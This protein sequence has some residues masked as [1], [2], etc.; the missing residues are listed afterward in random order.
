MPT[1]A[2]EGYP[3]SLTDIDGASTREPAESRVRRARDRR[4]VRAHRSCCGCGRDRIGA[5]RNREQT[6]PVA[7]PLVHGDTI[8]PDQRRARKVP[9]QGAVGKLTCIGGRSAD[10]HERP[11]ARHR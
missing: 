5:A 8:R 10:R 2:A 4:A 6:V 3:V 1:D 7:S 9:C 11:Q